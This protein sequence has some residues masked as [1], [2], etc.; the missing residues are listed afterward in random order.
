[1]MISWIFSL[2]EGGNEI[3]SQRSLPPPDKFI[4]HQLFLPSLGGKKAH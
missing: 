1:M 4:M 3:A 2:P